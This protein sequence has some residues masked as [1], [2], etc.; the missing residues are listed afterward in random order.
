MP[1]AIKMRQEN[2]MLISNKIEMPIADLQAMY[3]DLTA[4][5]SV[6]QQGFYI[7]FDFYAMDGTYVPWGEM[8]TRYFN[9]NFKF[10]YGENPNKFMPV[11][12][13]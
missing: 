1:Q 10:V 11:V 4:F 12:H 13:I 3:E 2:L 9:D 7:V 6:L 5:D 8:S